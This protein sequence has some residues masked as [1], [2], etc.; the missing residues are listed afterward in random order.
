MTLFRFVSYLCVKEDNV[1]AQRLFSAALNRCIMI[2][3]ALKRQRKASLQPKVQ[4][5]YILVHH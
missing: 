1:Y 5:L 3:H 4:K 2:E